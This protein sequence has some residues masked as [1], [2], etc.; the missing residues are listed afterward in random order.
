MKR[1]EDVFG[2]ID[3]LTG[4]EAKQ[5]L[6][7]IDAALWVKC[8]ALDT[9]RVCH[10]QGPQFDGDV[11]SKKDRDDLIECGAIIKVVVKG[12]GGFNACT[13]FGKELLRVGQ[14]IHGTDPF[15]D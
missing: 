2:R 13:Q 5:A 11:L 1:I 8:S 6:Q 3:L 14:I 7:V 4:N 10:D 9:L 15:S 12:E